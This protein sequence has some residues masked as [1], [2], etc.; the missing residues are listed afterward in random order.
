MA[1][2][3]FGHS[4]LS[5][6]ETQHLAASARAAHPEWFCGPLHLSDA[7]DLGPFG[8]EIA[9]EFGIAAQSRFGLFVHDKT[10]LDLLDRAA[11]HPY[12]PFGDPLVLTR[13]MDQ[14]RPPRSPT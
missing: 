7:G 6:R 4:A 14:P 11:D 5:I 3:L 10:H 2:E 8:A 9:L 1:I 12:A 13:G